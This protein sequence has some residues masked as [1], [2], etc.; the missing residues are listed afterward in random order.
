MTGLT[1]LILAS[2]KNMVAMFLL[3]SAVVAVAAAADCQTFDGVVIGSDFIVSIPNVADVGACCTQC[4]NNAGC[5]AFTFDTNSQTCFL[6]VQD[7]LR[8]PHRRPSDRC[9]A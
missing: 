5:I 3:L 2:L 8:L 7:A 9:N 4:Q 1:K 6:K